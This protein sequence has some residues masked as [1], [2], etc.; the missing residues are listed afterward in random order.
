MRWLNNA[1]LGFYSLI[2]L[3]RHAV[4]SCIVCVLLALPTS[5]TNSLTPHSASSASSMPFLA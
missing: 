3:I 4:S 5:E 2:N 1:N